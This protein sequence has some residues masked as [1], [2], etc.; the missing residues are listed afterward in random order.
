MVVTD[1]VA[2]FLT[3]IRNANTASHKAVRIP[4]SKLKR[5]I[6]R[7]LYEEG[8][9]VSHG[10]EDGQPY[11][12]IVIKLKYQGDTPVITG[13]RR[14]S[15]PG[16]RKYVGSD[17]IPAVLSGYGVAIHSTSKGVMTGKR[18]AELGV[19][20]EYLASVW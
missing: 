19:G 15:K 2:D 17:E 3:R 16:Q 18:A 6:A 10:V 12:S 1:P 11:K 7:V 5:E 13:L 8:Y 20:G 4:D 14:Q 9:V